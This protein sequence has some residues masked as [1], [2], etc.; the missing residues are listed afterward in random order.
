MYTGDKRALEN[1]EIFVDFITG[2]HDAFVIEDADH[3]LLAR[4]SGNHDLH[5]FLAIADGVVRAQGRKI[6]F[7][8]NLPNVSDIDEALLRPG[9]C[10]ARVRTRALTQVE[11]AALLARLAQ[12]EAHRQDVLA[13]VT[14]TASSSASLATVY[15]VALQV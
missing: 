9:R 10:F 7:T 4:S 14:P 8:T 1:D 15:R 11:T 2:S 13:K 6:I 12:D 3:M 5:R